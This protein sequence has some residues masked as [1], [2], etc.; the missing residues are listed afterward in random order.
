[1]FGFHPLLSKAV[2]IVI[3]FLFGVTGYIASATVGHLVTDHQNLHALVAIEQAR[4]AP[5][6]LPK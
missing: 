1:M 4:T 2:W 5:S 3:A 6:A